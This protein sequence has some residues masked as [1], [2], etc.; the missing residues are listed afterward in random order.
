MRDTPYI[1]PT[2]INIETRD[3][4][5]LILTN[6]HPMREAF[7]NICAPLAHWAKETPN[8]I[9]LC[10]VENGQW[11]KI[12][13]FEGWEIVQNLAA[14]LTQ[15]LNP[16][17]VVAIAS[18]NS[19]TH[20]FLTYAL[21]LIDCVP[22]PITPAYSLKA[23]DSRRLRG[24]LEVLGAVAVF[25]EGENFKRAIDWL[26]NDEF[27]IFSKNCNIEKSANKID[28][29]E[30]TNLEFDGTSAIAKIDPQNLC[31]VLLTS[32]STGVPKAVAISH[33]NLAQN[34]AQIRSTFDPAKEAQIWPEGIVMINHLPWSHSLGG[35]A[36]LHM[37]TH[38]G[39]NLWIDE[40][41]PTL[42]G[43]EKTIEAIKLVKPNYHNTVPLGWSLLA[44][45]M[46]NDAELAKALFEN[47]VIMQ[48]GGAALTADLYNR[49]QALAQKYCGDTISFAAGYGATETGPTACN[50]HWPNTIMGLVGLPVPGVTIKL[51]P[52]NDKLEARVKGP[53]ITPYYL[54]N[55]Q[56]TQEAFD[57][58][59]FYILGDAL[60][61]YDQ[62]KPE[63]GLKFNGRLSEEFKML[64]GSF[65][66]VSAIRLGI[67]SA[68]DGL[69]SD[70]IICG[71]GRDKL[72]ALLFLNIA[73]CQKFISEPLNNEI[74]AQN[75]EIIAN[76]KSN[77]AKYFAGKSTTQKVTNFVI[78]PNAPSLEEGEITDK[79]YLNQG[80]CREFRIESVNALYN[81][82]AIEIFEG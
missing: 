59:G 60:A 33:Y 27:V 32:G 5:A 8:K 53:A 66:Q 63:L 58:E 28:F 4:G 44:S 41:S 38:S 50:I 31:K 80:R 78:L 72:G 56:K 62:D 12:S 69:I 17:S 14:N 40:G 9:W 7:A 65:V 61:F 35:N 57:Q 79:G 42:E 43:L 82:K 64:N 21:P 15:Y 81:N 20:A 49:L 24:A 48:Y 19:L 18:N 16:K 11:R 26:A 25:F 74:L 34:A 67:I 73:N 23:S 2:Q 13:Y 55:P 70:A 29:A 75:H 68:C 54:N 76:I 47:L 1:S 22:A 52:H 77:L 46:E 36:I 45:A 51:L 30:F 3:D 37:I 71:E 6:P 39:A 10:G